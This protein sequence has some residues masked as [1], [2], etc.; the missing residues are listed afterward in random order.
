MV[1]FST[2]KRTRYGIHIILYELIMETTADCGLCEVDAVLRITDDDRTGHVD[3][4]PRS[5]KQ[6]SQLLKSVHT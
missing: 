3:H 2:H 5:R 1:K 6:K 4:L